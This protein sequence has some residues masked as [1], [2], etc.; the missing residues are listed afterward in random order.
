MKSF[1]SGAIAGAGLWAGCGLQKGLSG[2][3]KPNI[4]IIYA[5]DL[6]FGDVSCYGATAVSTP[7]IDKIAAQGIRFTNG[8]CT[9]ATCTPSR[10]S[11]LTGEYAFRQEGTG[12]ARG[13]AAMIIQPGRTTW[14]S[15]MQ[16]CGYKTGVVGKWHLGLGDGKEEL[17]WNKD[18]KPGP[19][20]IGFDYNFLV[21]ATGDRVPCVYVE[22]RRVVNLDKSD[23]IKVSYD[24]PFPGEPT[25]VS[26]RNELKLDWTHDHNDA[27]INGVGRLGYMI[28]GKSA[29]W[30]DETMADVLT[31]KAVDFIKRN[32]AN[33]FFLYF[34]THDVH[35]PRMPHNRFKD[36]TDMGSRGDVIV[37][38]DYCV[39]QVVKTLNEL[40]LADNTIL[41]ISSDNGP[42]LD[43]GYKD[44]AIER[45]GSHKPAGP[46]RG[47]KYSAFSGGTRVPLI[48]R[49]PDKIS[50]GQVSNALVS[51][52][53]FLASFAALNGLEVD[54]DTCGDSLNQID[55]L[56]GKD[57]TGRKHLIQ[58]GRLTL[59]L[60]EGKWK[61]IVPKKVSKNHWT[62]TNKFIEN[63]TSPK[64]Q[65]YDMEADIGE[66]N[67]LA[68]KY[69][70]IVKRMAA[71]LE[72]LI[73]A[74]KTI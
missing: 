46:L 4:V 40:G 17:D 9:S 53:D 2:S 21:P 55:A 64:E 45:V 13:N 71:K 24:E 5:D 56:L 65:L 16:Q 61:Y 31:G 23:P 73:E 50:G 44:Q 3:T 70:E 15:A 38:F 34:A 33:P 39:G 67:N 60:V 42:V 54:C 49:W 6:G 14:A 25:G 28:G 72:K 26:H 22:N 48:I 12:I 51:Q 43:D 10:Y 69:P 19:H 47:G 1:A 59:A 30:D 18:I 66:R 74:G 8:H 58:Q 11:M 52:V 27:I 32:K 29:I 36:K 35:V 68:E 62:I 41:I 20:E 7:N 63:G 57:K 37:Q